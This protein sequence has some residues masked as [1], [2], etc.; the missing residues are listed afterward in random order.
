[1]EA[2]GGEATDDQN[3]AENS[4]SPSPRK[5]SDVSVKEHGSFQVV[6]VINDFETD[7]GLHGVRAKEQVNWNK[8]PQCRGKDVLAV[9]YSDLF[10]LREDGRPSNPD[11][12]VRFQYDHTHIHRASG[13]GIE[14]IDENTY[15]HHDFSYHGENAMN[16]IYFKPGEFVGYRVDLPVDGQ[17]SGNQRG[18]SFRYADIY[19]DFCFS[20]EALFEPVSNETLLGADFCHLLWS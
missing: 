7:D 4:P 8:D 16:F 13:P 11:V 18:Y 9:A 14:T 2:F 12:T 20:L 15:T 17:Q 3:E 5:V 1:M 19:T 10:H 6:S